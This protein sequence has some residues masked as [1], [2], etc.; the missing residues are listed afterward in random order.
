MRNFKYQPILKAVVY[1][2]LLLN[3]STL[4]ASPISTEE[5]SIS[6]VTR[7]RQSKEEWLALIDYSHKYMQ[8]HQDELVVEKNESGFY[9]I[10][11]PAPSYLKSA[12]KLRLHY[13]PIDS[14]TQILEES[15]HDHPKLFE[16][17]IVN[18]GYRHA[19]YIKS[20]ASQDDSKYTIFKVNK[21]QKGFDVSG[22]T[23][24]HQDQIEKA[25]EN[26]VVIMSTD[27]IHRVLTYVPGTLSMN[28]V[29]EDSTN[30]D[31]YNVFISEDGSEDD[32]KTER[33]SL[34][35]AE[36]S[37]ILKEVL[38]RLFNSIFQRD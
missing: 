7:S 11:I 13:W 9:R 38:A 15:I 26:A 33:A 12:E 34:V 5:H 28:I 37:N 4:T 17:Y 36:K 27:V 2:S 8:E 6:E 24:L 14:S 35:G 29:Y 20:D 31:H 32:V 22:Q 3:T 10:N 16:S 19:L 25:R 23:Y 21:L 18:G 30:K 1:I